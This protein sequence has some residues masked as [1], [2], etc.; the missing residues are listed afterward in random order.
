MPAAYRDIGRGVW[1]FAQRNL[2]KDGFY[3]MFMFFVTRLDHFCLDV[4]HNADE[5]NTFFFC[6][7]RDRE[8]RVVSRLSMSFVLMV[9]LVAIHNSK[10]T[11]KM[12]GFSLRSNGVRF[13]CSEAKAGTES[14][15]FVRDSLKERPKHALHPCWL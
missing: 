3:G 12:Y 4:Y 10:A 11:S 14:S 9:V 6:N 5:R 13:G 1:I 8:S 2:G 7:G 15:A